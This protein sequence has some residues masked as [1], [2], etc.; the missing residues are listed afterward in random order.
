MGL[1][2]AGRILYVSSVD[3]SVGDGPGVNELEFARALRRVV[4]D[5][6]HFVIP[7][8]EFEIDLPRSVCSFARPHWRHHPLHVLGHH[9]SLARV[10][11]SILA[12]GRYDLIVFR[13]DAL[14]LAPIW[15]V[16]RHKVPYVIKTLGRGTLNALQ[17]RGLGLGKIVTPTQRK[18]VEALVHGAEAVDCVSPLMAEFLKGGAG[19]VERENRR[20][21]QCRRYG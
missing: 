2:Q 13:V 20:D 18:L 9:I 14:P 19:H 12:N 15:I 8:P 16:R 7:R 10:A 1:A 21:R 5:R 6:A 3:L 17:G 11:S 4:G